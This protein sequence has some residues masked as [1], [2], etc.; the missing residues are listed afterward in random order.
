VR[1]EDFFR[2]APPTASE[3]L[4]ALP[5]ALAAKGSA[6]VTNAATA[7]FAFFVLLGPLAAIA[8]WRLR[9]RAEV[10]AWSSLLVLVFF[11]QSLLWTLHSTRGSYFHSL[12]AFFP[13]GMALAAAA[14]ERALA[15]RDATIGRLWATG[16]LA[17]AVALSAGAL[18]QWDASFNDLARARTAA[19]DAIPPGP[20][21]AID[22]AAWRALS[23]RSVVVTPAD[24][25]AEL[26]CAAERYGARSLVLE[27]AH[28]RAYDR[29][30][31]GAEQLPW[32]GPPIA[33]GTIKIFPFVGD[34][35]CSFLQ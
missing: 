25:L 8:A 17:L 16:T 31:T 18:V 20:F 5:D 27:A 12:A 26:G 22:A 13:F 24:G 6:V 9:A 2:I 11:A 35:G 19:L 7:L 34:F 1:Y 4:G 21:I 15:R 23:G 30:Y 33:R 10:R 29:I 3:F 28:F 32:L 14:A